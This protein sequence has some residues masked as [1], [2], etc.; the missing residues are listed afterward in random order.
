MTHLYRVNCGDPPDGRR[1]GLGPR[2]DRARPL[3]GVR[4][5]G[6][7]R[8]RFEPSWRRLAAGGLR[9]P[10][11]A[12]QGHPGVNPAVMRPSMAGMVMGWLSSPRWSGGR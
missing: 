11:W 3:S 1:A 4:I 8:D 10:A 5:F 7:V 2:R 12:P 9:R 6:T